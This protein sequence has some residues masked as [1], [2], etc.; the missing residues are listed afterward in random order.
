MMPSHENLQ[1]IESSQFTVIASL[2]ILYGLKCLSQGNSRLHQGFRNL[3]C[4]DNIRSN[5]RETAICHLNE[6]RISTKAISK[7]FYK[8]GRRKSIS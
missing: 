3:S 5:H 8:F 2:Y 7:R 1:T 6:V 4:V